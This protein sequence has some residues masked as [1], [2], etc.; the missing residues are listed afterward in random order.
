MLTS[1]KPLGAVSHGP[2]SF[3]TSTV[4]AGQWAPRR[5]VSKVSRSTRISA[6]VS[7]VVNVQEKAGLLAHHRKGEHIALKATV[8]VHLKG[9]DSSHEKVA[10]M[11]HSQWLYL[12]F[13][14][15]ESDPSAKLSLAITLIYLFF[16]PLPIDEPSLLLPIDR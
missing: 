5:G 1:T 9:E 2:C 8:K 15:S 10:G 7:E 6:A 13:F 16:S 3:T 11:V 14:S 12:E 4:S